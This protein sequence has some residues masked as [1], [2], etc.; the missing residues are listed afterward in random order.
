[1]IGRP[2]A[3]RAIIN[4]L[5]EATTLD[6]RFEHRPDDDAVTIAAGCCQHSLFHAAKPLI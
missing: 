2:A 1:M 6:V 3:V 4:I 5:P